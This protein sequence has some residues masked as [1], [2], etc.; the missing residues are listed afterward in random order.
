MSLI[1]LM[2][3]CWI[4]VLIYFYKILPPN[5]SAYC[6]M[7]MACVLGRHTHIGYLQD[8]NAQ[9]TKKW[10]ENWGFFKQNNPSLI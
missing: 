4:E 2:H 10:T 5:F 9:G 1:V 7:H 8:S 3:P 6:V